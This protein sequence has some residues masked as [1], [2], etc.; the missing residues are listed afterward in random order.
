MKL[1]KAEKTVILQYKMMWIKR[2]EF[3]GEMPRNYIKLNN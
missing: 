2:K 1:L 3:L